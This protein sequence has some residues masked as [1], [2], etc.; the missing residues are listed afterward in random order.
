MASI[1]ALTREFAQL[2][3]ARSIGTFPIRTC[4]TIASLDR[5]ISRD[6]PVAILYEPGLGLASQHDVLRG[7]ELLGI[8]L[9][10]RSSLL[11][12]AIT[13]LMTLCRAHPWTA[14][15]IRPH[16]SLE[17]VSTTLNEPDGGPVA[18]VLSYIEPELVS[19]AATPFLIAPLVLGR[20]R[21]RG[22]EH[23]GAF[24][25]QQRTLESQ[26]RK[27]ALPEPRRMRTWG[28]AFWALWRLDRWGWL[29]KR[30]AANG[31]FATA[32]ALWETL[33]PV[34]RGAP[35]RHSR[36]DR[37][38]WAV[39][40]FRQELLRQSPN[41]LGRSIALSSVLDTHAPTLTKAP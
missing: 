39:S 31:G 12:S 13:E 37:V 27:L 32:S 2:N 15:S 14:V 10:V 34:M 26:H 6:P 21:I 4:G 5:E 30:A 24:S 36:T 1:V 18:S 20:R 28:A 35:D 23:A 40:Q 8:R 16:D 17:L 29:P 7:I 9:I 25:I 33:A 19:E 38:T 41:G 11:P 3:V 22:P